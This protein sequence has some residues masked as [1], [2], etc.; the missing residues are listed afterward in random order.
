MKTAVSQIIITIFMCGDVMTGRGID[1]VLP[2]PSDPR[3]YEPY[4]KNAKG[5]VELAEEANGPIL[6]PVTFSYIWGDALDEMDRLSP[7]VRLINLETAVTRSDD[8]LEGKGI[9][10]R[11]HPKNIPVITAAGIDVCALANNHVLDWGHAGLAETL[12]TLKDVKV[13]SAGAGCNLREAQAPAIVEVAGKGR[14]IVFSFG[15]ETSGIPPSWAASKD[16]PG[17]N[18]LKDLSEKTV[19]QIKKSIHAVKQPGDIVIAS[20]HWGG[21]W[22]FEISQRQRKF[23]HRLID[24]AGVDVIHGHSSHHVKG[25]EVYKDKSILYGCGDFITDYEG[26]GGYEWYRSDLGLMYFA[27]IDA[28]SGKLVDLRMTPTQIR[29]FKVNLASKA[30]ALWL[31][32]TLNR[33]GEKLGAQVELDKD[34]A[35]RL[36]W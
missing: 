36:Q 22:G 17:V 13:K 3:I 7:D 16:S 24:E 12:A 33:E 27:S 1:Q 34:N 19:R 20:I 35:L 5:Y 6:K 30:G 31:R 8:Y 28:A 29:N 21:N 15:S 2:Y 10:Y 4:L 32:D 18:R 11:M 23:A 26:I 25:I 14:V 9:N